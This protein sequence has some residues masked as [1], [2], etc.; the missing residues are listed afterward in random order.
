MSTSQNV[1]CPLCGTP[2]QV[3]D[4]QIKHSRHYLCSSCGDLVV[5][6]FA[7]DWLR[8]KAPGQAKQDCAAEAKSCRSSG[9]VY[10]ISQSR[11]PDGAQHTV[12]RCLPLLA[13]AL[14]L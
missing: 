5:K 3:V 4:Y 2:A 8:D 10:F 1:T 14:S 12:G 7:E 11:G 9:N 13:E 6:Y